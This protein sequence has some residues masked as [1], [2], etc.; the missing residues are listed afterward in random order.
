MTSTP[1]PGQLVGRIVTSPD[2]TNWTF[3]FP[4]SYSILGGV[5]YTHGTF[6]VVGEGG[7]IL[8]SDSLVDPLP[9]QL[10]NPRMANGAFQLTLRGGTGQVYRVDSSADLSNWLP[11]GTV[12]NA[13]GC[14]IFHDP[15]SATN[16]RQF[17]RAVNL[18]P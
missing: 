18:P 9:L 5:T 17:Y 12:T 4:N 15:N 3:R 2:G 7:T 6:I 8:Q 11:A 10:E 1:Q 14:V 16:Q 13:S